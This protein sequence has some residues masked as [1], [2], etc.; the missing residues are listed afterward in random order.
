MGVGSGWG[1]IG[2]LRARVGWGAYAEPAHVGW[3]WQMLRYDTV[4]GEGKGK[5]G[6]KGT[7][8]K[9]RVRRARFDGQ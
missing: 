4:R 3:R 5:E 7:Y 9:G 2:G 8:R 6:K 1:G